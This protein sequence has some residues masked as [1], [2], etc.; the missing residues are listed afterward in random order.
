[1]KKGI[2]SIVT[3]GAL[4]L[5]GAS[6]VQ[7]ENIAVPAEKF[8]RSLDVIVDDQIMMGSNAF[9]DNGRVMIE[10]R[11]IV[12]EIG[13][14]IQWNG[15]GNRAVTT[16]YD[17]NEVTLY[18]NQP[19]ANIAVI[20]GTQTEMDTPAAII[21]GRTYVPIRFLSEALGAIVA[22]DNTYKNARVMQNPMGEPSES[23]QFYK[24]TDP[25]GSVTVYKYERGDFPVASYSPRENGGSVTIHSMSSEVRH[26]SHAEIAAELAT[27]NGFPMTEEQTMNLK[28]PVLGSLEPREE[29]DM[30]SYTYRSYIPVPTGNWNLQW[31]FK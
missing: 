17:G 11:T 23:G 14:T 24:E 18:P 3:A 10:L 15:A 30:G 2:I 16:Y 25:D 20:N 21:E 7:A 26:F 31:E 9:M 6:A 19:N 8:D 5:G 27:Q 29:H 4:I 22:W 1:M 12:E 13:G 28:K